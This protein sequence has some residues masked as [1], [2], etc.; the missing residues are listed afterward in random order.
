MR[1]PW[2]IRVVS[3]VLL[4]GLSG[5]H[6]QSELNANKNGKETLLTAVSRGDLPQV[7]KLLREGSDPNEHTVGGKTAL[8]YAAQ[9]KNAAVVQA[10]IQ[11]GA[12]VNAEA[13]GNVTPLMLSLDMAF[14]RPEISLALIR[15]G[16]NVN[17]ADDNGDTALIIAATESSDEVF[18]TLLER[19]ANPNARGLNGETALHYVA[20]NGLLDRAKL[21]LNHGADP[22]IR[23]SGGKTPYDEAV[24][25]NPEKSVQA[26]FQEMRTLLSRASQR[27]P[28]TVT[29]S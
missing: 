25:T 22:T 20:M 29:K 8:H 19:G 15:A 1:L 2:T 17:S 16:A 26:Q 23:N 24:T 13:T 27:K 12:N 14:G 7:H 18:Q 28:K 11:A 3:T 5:C 9:S 6:G 21:L 10:L 4:I